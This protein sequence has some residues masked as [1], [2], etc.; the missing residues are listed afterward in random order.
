MKVDLYWKPVLFLLEMNSSG[1]PAL[2]WYNSIL[3]LDS[4]IY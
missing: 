3:A 1:K 4:V 2:H